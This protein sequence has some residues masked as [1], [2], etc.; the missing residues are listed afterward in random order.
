MEYDV[1][2]RAGGDAAVPFLAAHVAIDITNSRITTSSYTKPGNAQEMSHKNSNV[3]PH[4]LKSI[5]VGMLRRVHHRGYIII[6]SSYREYRAAQARLYEAPMRRGWTM[7]DIRATGRKPSYKDRAKII[8]EY[9]HTQQMRKHQVLDQHDDMPVVHMLKQI[10]AA[11]AISI[12]TVKPTYNHVFDDLKTLRAR[13]ET[14]RA[15]LPRFIRRT[16]HIVASKGAT[17]LEADFRR[18]GL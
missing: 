1:T 15:K 4:V 10:N 7:R 2:I 9:L 6:C 17:K 18:N 13:I 3:P 12:V 16:Q 5:I 8:Q 14:A 11:D